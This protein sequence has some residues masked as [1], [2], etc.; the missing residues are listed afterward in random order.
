VPR[1]FA[2]LA[3]CCC[4]L[5]FAGQAA[6]RP[7]MPT[8]T[9][10]KQEFQIEAQPLTTALQQFVERTGLSLRLE[11]PIG[12]AVQANPVSG[13][14]TPPQA[15]RQLLAG[16]ALEARFTSD[17]TLL[18]RAATDG[19]V[20][21][22]RPVEVTAVRSRGYAAVRSSTAMKTSTP[23]RDTPQSVSVVTRDVI[24]DQSMQSMADVVRYIPGVSMGQGE[25]HRDAP[26]I[27]GNSTTA[28]F[29]VDGVRDD[30]QYFRDLYNVERVET[31][32][33]SNAMIFGR[34]GGGGVIN[35][36][37]KEPQWAASQSLRIEGGSA[38]HRRGTLDIAQP[39]G[40]RFSVRVNGM[41]EDSRSYRD[42]VGIKRNA[43]N[44][45]LLY[46]PGLRTNVNLSYEYFDEDRTVDRGI[47][48]ANGLPSSAARST[49]FGNP[50]LSYGTA[51]VHTAGVLVEHNTASGLTLRNRSR[52][53]DYDKF[54]QNSYASG[55][56]TAAGK[57]NLGAYNS[58]TQRQ[59]LFNQTEVVAKVGTG[60]VRHTLLGGVE[61]ARQETDNFRNTGY[62]NNT[63]TTLAVDF[64]SPTVRAPITFRQSATDADNRAIV[65]VAAAYVQ[66]QI[67]VS[68]K[69]QAIGGVRFERFDI[70]FHN[71]RTNAGLDRQ[72]DL[73]SPRAG[74]VFKPVKAASLYTSY[75]VSY[76]PSSGDQF[77]S[78][79]ATTQ[80]LEPEQ[81]AN[82]EI[83]AKWDVRHNLSLTVA[84]Y[85]LDRTNTSA[86]D[87]VEAGKL[88]QTGEQRSRGIEV[89]LAG[90]VTSNW[91]V[92]AGATTQKAEITSTT[93]AAPAGA[94]MPLVPERTLSLW[95]R[96]DV[97][98]LI[99]MGV[100]VFH[101]SDVYA[102]IDNQVKLPSFTR[103]DGALFLRAHSLLQLQLN[104]ENLFDTEYFGT[105]HGNNNILP[106]AGRTFRLALTTR[107]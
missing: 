18:I 95:N 74:L 7:V 39:F 69:L 88:V 40:D 99:G 32:K 26:T 15:L 98:D 101:Q 13:S 105:S 60:S 28:D 45:T 12:S 86:P 4:A 22:L 2:G 76:L 5:A 36:V 54:Y 55:A 50:D 67:E 51:R 80:T 42:E 102:A 24:A 1:F 93:S 104:V 53:T 78:L 71:N 21:N 70:D 77:S 62:Y 82:R 20:Y 25:G 94:R 8:D 6:A 81:F 30:A 84:A 9:T 17:N 57:V 83:G 23:L 65:S 37:T 41:Y 85:Q 90:D 87:P 34:G 106:G 38:D 100:G 31:L 96:Y 107:R 43:L 91:H 14:Y 35:R 79:T 11:L 97:S 48:S 33:G 73:I 89:G 68:S 66:D 61:L 72:D 3:T 58:S 103:V 63:A 49:F 59:N 64:A 10:R 92:V 56:L 75:S 19:P 52:F 27:R 44:P 46:T 16:L 47:P 29:F